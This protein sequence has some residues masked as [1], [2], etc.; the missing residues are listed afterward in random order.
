MNVRF[1]EAQMWVDL[2]DG[3]T[4]GIPLVWFPRLLHATSD[5]R[6]D[7]FLSPSGLHWD[8]IDEDISV[9]GLLAGRGDQTRSR[10]AAA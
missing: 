8:E 2:E 3:R 10:K 1:D 7:F 6:A 4:L 5:Q 9:A